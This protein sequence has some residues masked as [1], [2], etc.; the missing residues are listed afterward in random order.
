[1]GRQIFSW[2][3]D[4]TWGRKSK[5]H[6]LKGSCG[7]GVELPQEQLG[8]ILKGEEGRLWLLGLAWCTEESE[9]FSQSPQCTRHRGKLCYSSPSLLGLSLLLLRC[10]E[11][12]PHGPR[13]ARAWAASQTCLGLNSIIHSLIHSFIYACIKSFIYMVSY[14]AFFTHRYWSPTVLQALASAM[15]SSASSLFPNSLQVLICKT[16]WCR[17]VGI[18]SKVQKTLST[19]PGS[20]LTFQYGRL[21]NLF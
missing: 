1:M 9:G 6:Q 18:K 8:K 15:W 13:Q 7:V 10:R 20:W 4:K 5:Q 2:G 14:S 16:G 21:G 19:G 12:R 11:F 3:N 17:I